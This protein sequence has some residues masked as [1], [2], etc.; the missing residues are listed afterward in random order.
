[1]AE[2]PLQKLFEVPSHYD[3]AEIKGHCLWP[4]QGREKDREASSWTCGLATL[5]VSV[6]AGRCWA[7]PAL[8]GHSGEWAEPQ[9][10]SLILALALPRPSHCRLA[11]GGGCGEK[12]QQHRLPSSLAEGETPFPGQCEDVWDIKEHPKSE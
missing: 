5:G 8:G 11:P 9:D 7:S 12:V 10:G 2:T 6:C 1:M 3:R 4:Q